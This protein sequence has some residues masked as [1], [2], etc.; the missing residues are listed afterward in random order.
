M[1]VLAELKDTVRIAPD[2]F[3]VKLVDAIRDEIDRKLANKVLLNVGLCIALKDIVSLQDSI[4][5][6]GD[7]ASHTA[8]VFRYIVFRPK[9]GTVVTGKIR[10]CSREGVHVT[11]GFFDDILIPHAA[12]QHPSRFDEAEQAW[13]WEYPLEDGAKHDLFMD[14]GEPIK[15]RVSREIFEETSPVGPPKSESQSTQ[16]P[17][18][19]TAAA[20][21]AQE[22]K[23]PYK[24]IGAINESGLGVLSW[25]DQQGKEDDQENEDNT[26]YDNDEDG[27]GACEE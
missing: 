8:V 10:S 11:L 2:Q 23:T 6:P 12:L 16:G 15:F 17:S 18:T 27:E 4:I 22:I 13:V 1:F 7:G 14:V 26:E 24:I 9:V 3:S 20:T 21:A 19:S 5:L 25:W